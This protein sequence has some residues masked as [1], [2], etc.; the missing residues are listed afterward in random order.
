MGSVAGHAVEF[1]ASEKAH[2]HAQLATLFDH[3][4]QAD[5]VTLLRHADPLEGAPPGFQ[6][7]GDGVDAVDI[8]HEVS[9]YRKPRHETSPGIVNGQDPE[10]R[11]FS[12]A[13]SRTMVEERRFSAA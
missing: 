6:C 7:L 4:L 13:V 5:V 10:G 1:H 8:V 2:G 9:V 11:D 12:R 3:A